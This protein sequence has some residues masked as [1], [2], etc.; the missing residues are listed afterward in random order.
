MG[1]VHFGGPPPLGAG[2]GLLGFGFW[3]CRGGRGVV[4]PLGWFWGCLSWCAA[5]PGFW[6]CQGV[7]SLTISRPSVVE[8][9][10]CTPATWTDSFGIST[11]RMSLSCRA[12]SVVLSGRP[13]VRGLEP[14]FATGGKMSFASWRGRMVTSLTHTKVRSRFPARPWA[15]GGVG[16][17]ADRPGGRCRG[18]RAT[19]R[20]D[21]PG[22]VVHSG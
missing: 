19:S 22:D 10:Q 16:R 11:R 1:P 5:A 6:L 18:L 8:E 7:A 3:F 9:C 13:V 12:G 15:S 4:P 17:I 14:V 20:V 2:V 21:A